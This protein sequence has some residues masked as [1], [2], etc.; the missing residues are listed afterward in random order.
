M[1]VRND[2]A[3][4]RAAIAVA[5]HSL[6]ERRRKHRSVRIRSFGVNGREIGFEDKTAKGGGTR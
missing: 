6:E 3:A 4:T 2:P 1:L 5:H